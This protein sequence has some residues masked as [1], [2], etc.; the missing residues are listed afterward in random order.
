MQDAYTEDSTIQLVV[1]QVEE[2]IVTLIEEIRERPG[3]AAAIFAALVGIM[4]G[5]ALAK[6]GRRKRAVTERVAHK[7]RGIGEAAE[8][9][10]IG[11]S[12]L[13]NPIVRAIILN[14]VKRRF[15]R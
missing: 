5:S 14:Q 1:D 3:V 4:I 15:S 13:E 8:L 9:A 6:R 11:L 7:A 12:L 10:G 2:L